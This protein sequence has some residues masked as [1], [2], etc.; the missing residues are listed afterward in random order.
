MLTYIFT[1]IPRSERGKFNQM[2]YVCAWRRPSCFSL[3]EDR[4]GPLNQQDN[5]FHQSQRSSHGRQSPTCHFTWTSEENAHLPLFIHSF[6]RHMFIEHL[7][8]DQTLLQAVETD[9]PTDRT[10]K[11]P[12]L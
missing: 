9:T 12:A 10:G 7:L 3:S 2:N 5:K 1:C 8:Y 6:I 11:K 4:A